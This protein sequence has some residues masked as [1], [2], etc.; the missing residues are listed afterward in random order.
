MQM[1][2]TDVDHLATST[3]MV[4]VLKQL[5]KIMRD[6][7]SLPDNAQTRFWDDTQQDIGE[8]SVED[9]RVGQMSTRSVTV[10]YN[11]LANM[12]GPKLAEM[13]NGQITEYYER[14]LEQ[15]KTV[16]QWDTFLDE[17]FE[18]AKSAGREESLVAEVTLHGARTIGQG[19]VRR[20]GGNS[21][22]LT[23]TTPDRTVRHFSSKDVS[24][25][26]ITPTADATL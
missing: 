8:V 16:S 1:R 13:V 10:L 19:T 12:C 24:M 17:Q 9:L 5:T 7:E 20:V 14:M 6:V 3:D 15:L 11:I 2:M 18:E 23:L 4:D 25:M 21:K 22:L 26:V